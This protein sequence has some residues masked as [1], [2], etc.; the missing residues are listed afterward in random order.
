MK[1][2]SEL[3]HTTELQSA[4]MVHTGSGNIYGVGSFV[5]IPTIPLNGCNL[6]N[7]HPNFVGRRDEID[8]IIEALS[9]RAWIVTIDG[10][11]GMGKTTLALEVAHICRER[12]T[13]YLQTPEFKG[14]VWVSARDKADFCLE[15]VVRAILYVFSP[16][17]DRVRELSPSEELGLAIRALSVE[18]RL[19]VIDNF[20]TVSDEPLHRFL[21][22]LPNPSKV[23][24]T[25]RH[26]IQ[27]GERVV[28]VGGLDEG[29]ALQLLRLEAARLQIPIEEQD[30][31]RLCIIA[32][33][34]YGIP[35]VL[36]WV[37]ESVYN[38]KSLE[39][40]LG[41]LEHATAQDIF[42]YIF[43]LSLSTVD[44][45]T[46]GIFRSMSLLPTWTSLETIAALNP[47]VPALQERVGHLVTRSLVED[48]R[49]LSL[50]NRRYQ[51]PS[52]TQYLATKELTDTD[53]K[54]ANI[55][56]CG[57]DY[58]LT[59]VQSMESSSAAREFLDA[60]FINVDSIVCSAF[61]LGRTAL[62]KKCVDV[63]AEVRRIDYQRGRTLLDQLIEPITTSGDETLI[64]LLFDS[65][66]NPHILASPV[67]TPDMFFGRRELLKFISTTFE[68]DETRNSVISLVGP[69]SIG[70][71]SL[72]Y[73]LSNQSSVRCRYLLADL[74]RIGRDTT[75]A[76]L[77]YALAH[78]ISRNLYENGL[79]ISP[80][81]FKVGDDPYLVFDTFIDNV[82]KGL[83]DTSLVLML[84][85]FGML[86]YRKE[87]GRSDTENVLNY[88]RSL[89][90]RGAL[91]IITAGVTPIHEFNLS[92]HDSPFFNIAISKRVS[93]LEPEEARELIQIPTCGLLKYEPQAIDHLITLSGGHPTLL[94]YLCYSIVESCRETCE[95]T[96]NIEKVES[97][98]SQIYEE[99]YYFFDYLVK[100]LKKKEYAAL[101]CAALIV[102]TI[103]QPFTIDHI[104]DALKQG[105][106]PLEVTQLDIMLNNLTSREMLIADELGS[107]RFSMEMFRRWIVMQSP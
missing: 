25:S 54:G 72:L 77:F 22:D 9:S 105:N 41:S 101:A 87:N 104:R 60:E 24:I 74:Q 8:K 83:G 37:M 80:Y 79:D 5:P 51:L 29:D 62:L 96:V 18:P 69:R 76:E 102:E 99:T 36:R 55:I 19:L 20:E 89:V 16:F 1:K 12:S 103:R 15:D 13:D 26:H 35:L 65:I 95:L 106:I 44:P 49:A 59:K 14:Y 78:I 52:F 53:D 85:E 4:N 39:W 21:R 81:Q 57:L 94:Q 32:R 93:F 73:R 92:G 43:S 90:Q 40:V 63:A 75:A 68:S 86:H 58:F 2:Q 33:K 50:A 45:E 100:S 28:T 47:E 42:D 56:E 6:P 23:L 64:L 71:T 91:N 70:K 82:N 17:E 38:G 11:G 30:I 107:Y 3:H 46:R 61:R 97:V 10:M 67:R 88:F 48:N 66:G 7:R 84:D 98:M 31:E 27:T 34:T